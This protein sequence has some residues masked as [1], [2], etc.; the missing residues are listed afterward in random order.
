M[1]APALSVLHVINGLDQGGAQRVLTALVEGLALHGVRQRVVCTTR[2]GVYA[3]RL[4]DSGVEVEAYGARSLRDVGLFAWLRRAIEGMHPDVVHSH[5]WLADLAVASGTRWRNPPLLVSTHHNTGARLP[6]WVNHLY[7]VL[8]QRFDRVLPVSGAVA[9]SLAL[10]GVRASLQVVPV[11]CVRRDYDPATARAES[12]GNQAAVEQLASWRGPVCLTAARLSPE[13]RIE[14]LFLAA[15]RLP[16]VLFLIAG[17]GPE[18]QRLEAA[19]GRLGLANVRFVGWV[20]DLRFLLARSA[21]A[22]LCSD[23]EGL[24]QFVLEAMAAGVAV[25]ATAVGGIPELV[26]SGREGLLV[27]AG[28]AQALAAA[29]T[30]MLAHA[31]ERQAMADAARARFRAAYTEERMIDTLLAVYRELQC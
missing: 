8:Y 24:P 14:L 5:L 13:K 12:V 6:A 17:D 20:H 22:A 31:Q 9:R 25:V 30:R 28:D 23:T 15:R 29:L 7:P 21:A 16:Q 3:D 4:A 1:P 10:R 26:R 18:R 19:A 11:S 2:G 27:P